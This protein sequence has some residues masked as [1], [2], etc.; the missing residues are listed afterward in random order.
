MDRLK[1]LDDSG[2]FAISTD[3]R[4]IKPADN[5]KFFIAGKIN[6]Y[7]DSLVSNIVKVNADGSKDNS[8][9]TYPV[10]DFIFSGDA[11]DLVVQSDGK[12][13]MIGD[14]NQYH[15]E[16]KNGIVRLNTDGTIDDS[17]N[18]GSGFSN[19]G[20]NV[21]F[22]NSIAQQADGKLIITGTLNTYNGTSIGNMLRL[23]TDGSLDTSFN[24]GAPNFFSNEGLNSGGKIKIDDNGKIYVSG[25]GNAWPNT[26]SKGIV[27]LNPDGSVD[28]SFEFSGFGSDYYVPRV[29]DIIIDGCYVYIAGE[30]GGFPDPKYG[31]LRLFQDGSVD[32]SFNPVSFSSITSEKI[33][34]IELQ[35]DGKIIAAG[36][37]DNIKPND[38]DIRGLMRLNQDGSLDTTFNPDVDPNSPEGVDIGLS[39]NSAGT[40][41]GIMYESTNNRLIAVGKFDSY[42]G[43]LKLPLI[44]VHASS[45]AAQTFSIPDANFEQALIDAN[46]DSDGIVNSQMKV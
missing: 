28:D 5:G 14:F 46:I 15:D 18:I 35:P 23:N 10:D 8:F 44:A 26:N 7:N 22:F 34:D 45:A 25:F 20:S 16:T 43:T 33:F 32:T 1:G 6:E 38:R 29:N 2:G 41:K 21:I 13:V 42:N 4:V 27:R 19:I 11:N 9:T 12:V 40:V 36:Q 17:F 39:V 31:I 24:P 37:F 3:V 30:F